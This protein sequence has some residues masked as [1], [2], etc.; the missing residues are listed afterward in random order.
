MKV[1]GY[2]VAAAG[3]VAMSLLFGACSKKEEPQPGTQQETAA[4]E[5][6]SY[7][8]EDVSYGLFFDEKGTQRTLTLAPDQR[9]F[10]LYV[11]LECPEYMEIAAVEWR[12]AVPEGVSLVNDRYRQ[13]RV[14]SMGTMDRGLSERFTPCIAGPKITL[15]TLTFAVGGKLENAV[16]SVMPSLDNENLG[17]AE[18]KEGFP[19]VRATSYKAV[20]N[21]AQ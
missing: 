16:F 2:G 10:D 14:L 1:S 21:P 4:K 19:V 20:V 3:L 17:V 5:A 6:I 12:I 15:H 9:E 7:I 8:D 11:I 18:C 13:D